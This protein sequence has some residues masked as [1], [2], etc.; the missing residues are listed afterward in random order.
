[1]IASVGST[2][3][4]DSTKKFH[5]VENKYLSFAEFLAL[6][7]FSIITCEIYQQ[8]KVKIIVLKDKFRLCGGLKRAFIESKP[9]EIE[10]KVMFPKP[11]LCGT[12][13]HR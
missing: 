3:G 4:V 7:C 5:C 10:Y 12:M 1:M 2:I 8:K 11:N 6:L 9:S 13:H